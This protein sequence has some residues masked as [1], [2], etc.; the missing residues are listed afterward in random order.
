MK[1]ELRKIYI[2][3][4]VLIGIENKRVV[5]KCLIDK[6]NTEDR[7]FDLNCIAGIENPKYLLLG[8]MTG[9]N[10]IDL[11]VCNAKDFTELFENKFKLLTK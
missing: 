2:I 4:A 7:S 10:M 9:V 1:T 11:T 6:N 8:I 3:P 5:L